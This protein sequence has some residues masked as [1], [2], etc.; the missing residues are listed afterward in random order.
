MSPILV[1]EVHPPQG[2][3]FDVF[4]VRA[5]VGGEH[6]AGPAKASQCRLEFPS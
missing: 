3:P 1:G 4:T 2:D 6:A 5:I